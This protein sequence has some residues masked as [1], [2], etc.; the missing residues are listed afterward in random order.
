MR[1]SSP[2][3]TLICRR[4][5]HIIFFHLCLLPL[6]LRYEIYLCWLALL[7]KTGLKQITYYLNDS[8]QPIWVI[9]MIFFFCEWGKW[10]T[11]KSGILLKVSQ[12]TLELSGNLVPDGSTART[13]SLPQK[14]LLSNL[15]LRPSN[16]LS[17]CTCPLLFLSSYPPSPGFSYFLLRSRD[18]A[19]MFFCSNSC[20]YFWYMR[21][22]ASLM[23]VPPTLII[24]TQF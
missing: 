11:A 8:L 13:P 17:E 15:G 5:Q 22:P 12:S 16:A 24:F 6:T 21:Q 2:L 14:H 4:E 10:C 20:K 3:Y 9:C 19:W 7:D 23:T 18:K 1:F